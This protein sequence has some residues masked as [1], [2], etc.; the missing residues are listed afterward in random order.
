MT[1]YLLGAYKMPHDSPS[2]RIS[3]TK[4]MLSMLTLSFVI[5]LIPGLWG[6]PLKLISG[7]P[8]PQFY[9]ESPG[10]FG[11]VQQLVSDASDIPDGADPEHCP[12]EL[13]CFHEFDKGLAYAK[14]VNK[15]IMLD[16]TGWGCVELPEDGGASVE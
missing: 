1:L 11:N 16:F 10:G 3:V 4:L 12:H 13:P 8:P 14:D 5:Y 6:A 7:F 9:S 15:P 2:D